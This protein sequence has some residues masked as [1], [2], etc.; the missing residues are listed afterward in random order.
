MPAPAALL[1]R[2]TRVLESGQAQVLA[3]AFHHYLIPCAPRTPS[4]NFERMQQLVT[5]GALR[6][7]DRVVGVMATIEDVTP[8]LDAERALAA[9]LQSDDPEA[10]GR[11]AE[12]LQAVDA[13]HAPQ[14]F[15]DALRHDSWQVRRAAVQGLSRHAS[16]DLLASLIAA[17]RDEHHDFNVLSSALQ[18]LVDD[19]RGR[20]R[21]ARRAAARSRSRPAHPGGAGPRRTAPSG[22]ERARSS[23]RST[24]PT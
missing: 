8:R 13:L 22:R 21:P 19:R 9:D 10:R 14:A 11:A 12:R 2:F 5:L 6:E 7:G 1:D 16:R 17:L 3:P 24:I 4:P 18:L 15:T 23:R 20:H